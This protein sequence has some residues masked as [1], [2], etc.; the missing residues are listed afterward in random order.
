MKALKNVNFD[1]KVEIYRNNDDSE[2][3]EV[4]KDT[5]VQPFTRSIFLTIYHILNKKWKIRKI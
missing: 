3:I 4:S 1:K 5:D 2:N